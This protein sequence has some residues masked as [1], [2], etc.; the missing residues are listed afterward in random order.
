[1]RQFWQLLGLGEDG[2][3]GKIDTG[4][5]RA[6]V[7]WLATWD[8]SEETRTLKAP[9]LALAAE[10]DMIVRAP[11]TEGCWGEGRADLR[12]V[13]TDSHL[14]PMTHAEWCAEQI[15]GFIRDLDR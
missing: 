3:G 12:W 5:L 14:L 10:D 2:P 1:M 6:G 7:D 15:E 8:A 11:M 4:A 13:K 9:I